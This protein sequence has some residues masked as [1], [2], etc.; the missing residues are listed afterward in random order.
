MEL[1][2]PRIPNHPVEARG[3]VATVRRE[4]RGEPDVRDPCSSDGGHTTSRDPPVSHTERR[5]ERPDESVPRCSVIPGHDMG[6]E[7]GWPVAP[8]CQSERRAR[9]DGRMGHAVEM[10]CGPVWSLGPKCS[11]SFFLFLSIFFFFYF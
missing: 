10:N 6:A 7:G 2:V 3:S 9:G 5:N 1:R 11:F 8:R 4:E